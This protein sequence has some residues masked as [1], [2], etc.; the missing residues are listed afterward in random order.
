MA[1]RL[2]KDVTDGPDQTWRNSANFE[3]GML[4]ENGVPGH[5]KFRK[6]RLDNAT[7]CSDNAY[8]G[9]TPKIAQNGWHTFMYRR[10]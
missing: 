4:Y 10:P 2:F 5:I 6:T 9:A 7:I 1:L 8:A 3:L